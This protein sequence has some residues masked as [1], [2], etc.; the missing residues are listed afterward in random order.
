MVDDDMLIQGLHLHLHDWEEDQL[1]KAGEG[2]AKAWH[3]NYKQNQ[4]YSRQN[5]AMGRVLELSSHRSHQLDDQRP[6]Q[7]TAQ[8]C[9]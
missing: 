2:L 4:V 9:L 1:E 8:A 3:T 6:A 5:D 7:T